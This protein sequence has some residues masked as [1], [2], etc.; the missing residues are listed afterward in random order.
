[1]LRTLVIPHRNLNTLVNFGLTLFIRMPDITWP[2]DRHEKR[3]LEHESAKA[4][5]LDGIHSVLILIT[6]FSILQMY[7][8]CTPIE[9]RYRASGRIPPTLSHL[10][11]DLHRGKFPRT[12]ACKSLKGNKN[13]QELRHIYFHI[14]NRE[15][16]KWL[17]GVPFVPGH[18]PKQPSKVYSSRVPLKIL[19]P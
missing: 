19:P 6:S 14:T 12:H 4:F 2:P 11:I 16:H 9:G 8:L 5:A 3:F 18:L 7:P 1:M 10:I 17:Y 13:R 15:L